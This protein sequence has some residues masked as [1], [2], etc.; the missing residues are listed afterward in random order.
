[1]LS[2]A[3]S[4]SPAQIGTLKQR[5][6]RAAG[7]SVGAYVFSQVIRLASNLIMSRLLVPEM[8]GIMA[9]ATMVAVVLNVLSDIGVDQKIIQSRRGEDPIFLD[10]AWVIQISRALIVWLF[11]LLASI[12]LH[13]AGVFALLP[14]NSVY[15]SPVLPAVIAVSSISTLILGFRSTK[16]AGAHRNFDQARLAKIELVSQCAALAVMIPVGVMTRSIWALVLGGLVG[17]F[18]T[19]LLSHTWLT[20][21]ANRWRW[22]RSAILE[23]VTFGR[24]I[25]LSSALGV[26]AI[27]GDRLLLGG[28]VTAHV[29][30]VYA[31]ALLVISSIEGVMGRLV[32]SVSLPALSEIAR[33]DPV[34]MR[35]VYYK[36]RIPSDFAFLFVAG[37]LWAAGP[38]LID[39][40]YDRRYSEA[41]GILQILALSLFTFRYTVAHQIYLAIGKPHFMTV[42]SVV[43]FISLYVAV[44]VSY[45]MGGVEP[46]IW[47]IALH[48]LATLPFVFSFNARLRLNDF[49]REAALLVFLPIGYAF[50]AALNALL[51]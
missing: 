45:Y 8:F 21:H 27:N 2:K 22:E 33:E 14:P 35:D 23:L 46:A 31:I 12:S 50:G 43:R 4:V 41:G 17:A 48:G 36:L 32:T 15:A 11:A 44:P 49:S 51:R 26:L 39:M 10:T 9:I 3:A 24:W 28:L 40:L 1:M 13:V 19:T 18:I 16:M 25:M 6:F 38:L 42:I 7:W 20:G 30:G 29:L 34:R 5:A 47:A 37:L